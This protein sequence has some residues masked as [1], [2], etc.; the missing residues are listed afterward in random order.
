M[1]GPEPS[2]SATA[3]VETPAPRAQAPPAVTIRGNEHPIRALAEEVLPNLQGSNL[4]DGSALQ[5]VSELLK[6]DADE[7]EDD[8]SREDK[9]RFCEVVVQEIEEALRMA[10]VDNEL[11]Y[12]DDPLRRNVLSVMVETV[13]KMIASTSEQ[14]D[15]LDQLR[16]VLSKF[17]GSLFLEIAPHA[18]AQRA[19]RTVSQVIRNLLR[20]AHVL[21]ADA[22]QL[23][24]ELDHIVTGYLERMVSY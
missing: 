17:V 11:E 19:I 6:A 1:P 20:S 21:T 2:S 7:L 5:R 14:E 15:N 10:C 3:V 4:A 22:S 23:L 24:D 9:R 12:R 16:N 13:I 8:E 18:G